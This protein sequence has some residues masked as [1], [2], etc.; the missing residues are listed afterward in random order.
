MI[1]LMGTFLSPRSGFVHTFMSSQHHVYK[2]THTHRALQSEVG[3]NE[4]NLLRDKLLIYY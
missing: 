2:H 4:Q 3:I 1:Y